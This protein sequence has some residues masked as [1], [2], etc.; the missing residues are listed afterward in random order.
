L[1]F[2]S[3][4]L[5]PKLSEFKET[6]TDLKPSLVLSLLEETVKKKA[7]A[8]AMYAHANNKSPTTLED[9]TPLKLLEKLSRRPPR[10]S[11]EKLRR[12]RTK[13]KPKLES[14]RLKRKPR[15]PKLNKKPLMRPRKSSTPSRK[16]STNKKKFMPKKS[17]IKL[18]RKL[19]S[20]PKKKSLK[21]VTMLI[22]PSKLKLL[23]MPLIKPLLRLK[24]VPKNQ[25]KMPPPLNLLLIRPLLTPL[26]LV[27]KLPIPLKPPETKPKPLLKE[28]KLKPKVLIRKPVLPL[29]KSDPHQKHE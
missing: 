1:P 25:R 21:S 9:I 2:F 13:R 20:K 18:S 29:L 14:R 24:K 23:V 6:M 11:R 12:E 26:P 8:N 27:I 19:E 3:Q 15:E 22:K 5:K 4:P 17:K 28:L 10:T 7:V 16:P